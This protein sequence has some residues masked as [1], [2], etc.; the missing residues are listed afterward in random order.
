MNRPVF[1][2]SHESTL[3]RSKAREWECHWGT[4]GWWEWQS[5]SSVTRP[6][7]I[8]ICPAMTNLNS[9]PLQKRRQQKVP[10][11][12]DSKSFDGVLLSTTP[13]ILPSDYA[14]ALWKTSTLFTSQPWRLVESEWERSTKETYTTILF[15]FIISR[16]AL[17]F[18]RRGF[19]LLG[20]DMDLLGSATIFNSCQRN[21]SAGSVEKISSRP[22]LSLRQ[23]WK[24][25][26]SLDR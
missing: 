13:S 23:H 8:Y 4:I 6:S 17:F 18:C 22:V 12:D 5:R 16:G 26:F 1:K 7:T 19:R 20:P 10:I 21:S 11:R 24:S 15:Y 9:I 3:H 14:A 25:L 2:N